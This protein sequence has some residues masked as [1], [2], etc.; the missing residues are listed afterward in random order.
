MP[1]WWG[2]SV[3]GTLTAA[4]TEG[5]FPHYLGQDICGVSEVLN[6]GGLHLTCH[7]CTVGTLR[8]PPGRQVDPAETDPVPRQLLALTRLALCAGSDVTGAGA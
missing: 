7:C 2:F 3:L 8:N 1:G 4:P 5:S 6:E